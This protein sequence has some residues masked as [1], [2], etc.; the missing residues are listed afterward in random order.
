MAEAISGERGEDP[1][2]NG[3]PEEE[4]EHKLEKIEVGAW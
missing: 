3:L 2:E 4:E 1:L